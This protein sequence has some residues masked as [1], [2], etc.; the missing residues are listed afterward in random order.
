MDINI[1]FVSYPNTYYLPN[2][3]RML[4]KEH[5]TQLYTILIQKHRHRQSNEAQ[6]VKM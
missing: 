6:G 1:S 3:C 2:K 5:E 4:E